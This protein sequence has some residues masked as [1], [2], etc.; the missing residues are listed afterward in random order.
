MKKNL[1]VAINFAKV[2]G[3]A[4]GL[5]FTLNPVKVNAASFLQNETAWREKI[6]AE[7]PNAEIFTVAF[8]PNNLA[9]GITEFGTFLGVPNPNQELATS[10][11]FN[12]DSTNYPLSFTFAS[13]HRTA[14]LVFADKGRNNTCQFVCNDREDHISIGKVDRNENDDWIVSTDSRIVGFAF[15]LLDNANEGFESISIYD[16]P[17]V[18]QERPIYEGPIHAPVIDFLQTPF[19]PTGRSRFIGIVSSDRPF[20]TIVFDE[21][22]RPDDI[23]V[24]NFRFAVVR[25]RESRGQNSGRRNMRSPQLRHNSNRQPI[26]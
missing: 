20:Q 15:D 19:L 21:D 18:S 26:K 6:L 7:N 10:L 23:A 12:R 22:N 2:I 17:V 25:D 4:S 11:S 14:K 5:I 13:R 16:E 3:L 1:K 24:R 9:V 8:T